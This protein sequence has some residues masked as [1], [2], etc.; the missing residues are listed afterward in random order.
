MFQFYCFSTVLYDKK[1]I[2]AQ[3]L[4]HKVKQ[5]N[6]TG[7]VVKFYTVDFLTVYRTYLPKL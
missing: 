5:R 2:F 1:E 3:A 4:F 7:L 6:E